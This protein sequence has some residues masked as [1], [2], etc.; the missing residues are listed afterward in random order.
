MLLCRHSNPFQN[1][2]VIFCAICVVFAAGFFALATISRFYCK[3]VSSSRDCELSVL[4]PPP[5]ADPKSLCRFRCAPA[6][7]RASAAHA[8]S[9]SAAAKLRNRCEHTRAFVLLSTSDDSHLTLR[10][11]A[12]GQR[13]VVERIDGLARQDGWGEG[14][15]GGRGL[16]QNCQ[17][18]AGNE[19]S[20]IYLGQRARWTRKE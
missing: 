8:H 13:H 1:T 3:D 2:Y 4:A 12:G 18:T 15:M 17:V 5:L 11:C 10:C 20:K 6:T 14:G 16:G 7:C 9:S 19:T